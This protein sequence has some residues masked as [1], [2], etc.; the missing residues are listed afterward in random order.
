MKKDKEAYSVEDKEGCFAEDKEDYFAELTII[1][2]IKVSEI[3]GDAFN[4]EEFVRKRNEVMKKAYRA[5]C[6]ALEDTGAEISRVHYE[7]I[8]IVSEI[9]FPD[10]SF[11]E[12][13]GNAPKP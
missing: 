8:K 12:D 11:L 9:P 13:T 3:I 10:Y 7:D 2:E 1:F 4:V 6:K 5:L